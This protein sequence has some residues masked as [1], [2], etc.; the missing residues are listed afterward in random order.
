MLYKKIR[1]REKVVRYIDIGEGR[2]ILFLHGLA[3]P[4]SR[5][6]PLINALARNNRVIAP[7]IPLEDS[8]K[9]YTRFVKSFLKRTDHSPQVIVAHS[10]GAVIAM[11]YVD[12]VPGIKR[13]VDINP[14]VNMP[15]S[16][17]GSI[18]RMM[19]FR[20][21]NSLKNLD[22]VLKSVKNLKKYHSIYR[23]VK[24]V[25]YIDNRIS[26]NLLLIQGKK[27]ELFSLSK[28]MEKKMRAHKNI[29]VVHLP[30]E[31]HGLP[32]NKPKKTSK[33]VLDFL[34]KK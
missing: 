1:I 18:K 12:E 3:V 28:D 19:R 2:E 4:L 16:F 31:T 29:Q 7:E 5:Y 32:I 21:R 26:C 13:E 34:D 14:P 10:L 8:L 23:H 15:Y 6:H 24:K 22:F 17:M 20:K 33:I 25:N 11:E 27:D 30:K 9:K